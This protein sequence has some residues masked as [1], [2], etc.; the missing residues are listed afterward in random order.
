[1][2]AVAFEQVLSSNTAVNMTLS[3]AQSYFSSQQNA[4]NLH[5]FIEPSYLS[6]KEFRK[7]GVERLDHLSL[8]L[9]QYKRFYCQYVLNSGSDFL[10]TL[11]N[12]KQKGLSQSIHSGV[13]KI[14]KKAIEQAMFFNA[15]ASWIANTR[16]LISILDDNEHCIQFDG[17]VFV[18]TDDNLKTH[19]D[20]CILAMEVA[21]DFE[22]LFLNSRKSTLGTWFESVV[23]RFK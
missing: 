18:F 4:L 23:A 21:A 9:S 17:E 1:M 6:S 14:E 8:L 16:L 7:Q 5:E 13:S 19:F 22:H 11:V 2:E 3:E 12:N 20:D 15:R 10:N